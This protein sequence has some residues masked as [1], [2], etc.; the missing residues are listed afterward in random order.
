MDVGKTHCTLV[1]DL[2]LSRPTDWR[3]RWWRSWH[4][5]ESRTQEWGLRV[6]VW[7]GIWTP[8]TG[9]HAILIGLIADKSKPR[10]KRRHDA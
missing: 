6:Q 9:K 1:V 7:T 4:H 5:T 8:G 2:A 10:Q 3:Q